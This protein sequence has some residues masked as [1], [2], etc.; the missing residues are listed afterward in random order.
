MSRTAHHDC[1]PVDPST[2]PKPPRTEKV[3]V[4][5]RHHPSQPLCSNGMNRNLK[6]LITAASLTAALIIPGCGGTSYP[7]ADCETT[8]NQ[9]RDNVN[10]GNEYAADQ[11]VSILYSTLNQCDNKTDWKAGFDKAMVDFKDTLAP[12]DLM[13]QLCEKLPESKV[14]K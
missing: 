1:A 8:W 13:S 5:P 9:I 12:D 7:T 6:H 3:S 10:S 4:H 2:T 11:S 14:C